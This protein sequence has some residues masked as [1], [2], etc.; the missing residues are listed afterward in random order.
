MCG[1]SCGSC[2]SPPRAPPAA[3][4]TRLPEVQLRQPLLRTTI[5]FLLAQGVHAAT[6]SA[7]KSTEREKQLNPMLRSRHLRFGLSP[8]YLLRRMLPRLAFV[9]I[10]LWLTGCTCSPSAPARVV[11]VVAGGFFT[12]ARTAAGEVYC[13]G[14][15]HE[16]QL[17]TTTRDS[18]ANRPLEIASLSGIDQISLGGEHGCAARIDE[19]TR[20]WGNN[21]YGQL[22]DETRENRGQPTAAI[23]FSEVTQVVA[24]S[25]R[26]CGVLS[27][28]RVSCV[29]VLGVQARSSSTQPQ[30][31]EGLH[32]IAEIAVGSG[33]SC[34]RRSTGQVLCWGSNFRGE[35]GDGTTTDRAEPV[36]VIGIATA[37]QIAVGTRRSCALLSD[38]S[39]SCWGYDGLHFSTTPEP[40]E[41]GE[42]VEQVAVGES[43]VCARHESGSIACWG[44]RRWRTLGDGETASAGDPD[45]VMYA[46]VRVRGIETAIDLAVGRRHSCAVLADHTLTCWGDNE[47]S[48]LGDGTRISRPTPVAIPIP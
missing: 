11:D 46:P 39:V 3:R 40:V 48:Q 7:A 13:W 30:I 15:N 25:N 43:H 35:L 34:A 27:D 1:G 12:C 36:A 24:G 18:V 37:T 19:S 45:Y 28:H 10:P 14:L 44:T 17:G 32:D 21:E 33:H 2:A 42:R 22:G 6:R 20:C 23:G 38:A 9:V 26:T 8:G 4:L 47:S 5:R 29:G 16:G 41:T 31:I